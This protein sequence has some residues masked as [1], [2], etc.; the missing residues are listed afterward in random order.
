MLPVGAAVGGG[1]LE[2]SAIASGGRGGRRGEEEE[3]E[4]S[5]EEEEEEG[6]ESELREGR[7]EAEAVDVGFVELKFAGC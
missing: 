7:M 3:E 6:P 2:V 5:G 4:D 1:V